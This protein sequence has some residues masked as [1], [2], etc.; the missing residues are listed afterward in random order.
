[1]RQSSFALIALVLLPAVGS[2]QRGG[3]SGRV[4][5]DPKADWNSVSNA[6]AGVKL[7]S[8]DLESISPI[9][10]LID[11]RKD[12]KLS[13]DQLNRLKDVENKLKGTNEPS[14]KALDSLRRAA[15]APMH[16]GEITDEERD[17]MTSAR[18]AMM[19]VVATVRGN[20]EEAL[21]GAM[22]I[23]DETQQKAAADLIEKQKKDAE[24]LI[25]DR[26]GGRG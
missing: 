18:R 21:T 1:M 3:S 5:G 15:Q 16:S 20:Y 12:L 6:N 14:F 24:D 17:R 26:M 23:L 22:P 25:R 2:A 7:S 8:R 11:K 10:L 13:D 9:H 19:A 4:R